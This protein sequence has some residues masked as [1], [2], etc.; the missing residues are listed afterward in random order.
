MTARTLAQTRPTR[1]RAWLIQAIAGAVCVARQR[2][3]M[4]VPSPI[5]AVIAALDAAGPVHGPLLPGRRPWDVLV[6]AVLSDDA[7]I[8]QGQA[9]IAWFAEHFVDAE[10]VARAD[11]RTLAGR[12]RPLR[13][14]L[15]KAR[16]VVEAARAIRRDH[17]G[18]IPMDPEILARIPGVGRVSA[19]RIAEALYGISRPIPTRNVQRV[20]SRWGWAAAT[21]TQTAQ[22]IA[23]AFASEYWALR[24]HQI[25]AFATRHCTR[26]HPRCGGCPLRA[27]CPSVTQDLR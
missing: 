3:A 5:S 25:E 2:P 24:S 4:T 7:P 18:Q 6:A 15:A 12:L 9:A 27:T 19:A 17:A 14:Y 26:Q 20:L 23:T 16:G 13:R 1:R 21:T 22:T 11:P 10:S 8:E